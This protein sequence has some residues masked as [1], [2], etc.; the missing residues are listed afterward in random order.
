MATAMAPD[1]EPDW[2]ESWATPEG[3][4]PTTYA[5]LLWT[6]LISLALLVV[7]VAFLVDDH[8]LRALIAA[9]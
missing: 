2:A 6:T 5:E 1:V 8:P 7:L 3:D 4:P 9:H